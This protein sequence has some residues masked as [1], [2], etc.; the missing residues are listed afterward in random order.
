[1]SM[2]HVSFQLDNVNYLLEANC[3]ERI[4]R[5]LSDRVIKLLERIGKEAAKDMYGHA[6]RVTGYTKIN[7][8]LI[9]HYITINPEGLNLATQ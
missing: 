7:N 9:T 5:R 1:M 2:M 3:N 4:F 8:E 6:A